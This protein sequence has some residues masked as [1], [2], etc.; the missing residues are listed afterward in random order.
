MP[1][2][3]PVL[4][5]EDPLQLQ[6]VPVGVDIRSVFDGLRFKGQQDI[7]VV[8]GDLVLHSRLFLQAKTTW[9]HGRL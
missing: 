6:G 8:V 2:A 5:R 1:R 3:T 4:R 9:R 7:D